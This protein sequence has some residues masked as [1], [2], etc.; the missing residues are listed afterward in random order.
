VIVVSDCTAT[1]TEEEQ[2]YAEKWI[3]PKIGRVMTSAEFLAAL[4]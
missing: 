3:F 4:S 2:K 1:D